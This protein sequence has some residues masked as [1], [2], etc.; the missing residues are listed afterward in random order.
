MGEQV[1][2]HLTSYSTE[3]IR[4]GVI[5]G[6]VGKAYQLQL[7][8]NG[9]DILV[10]TPGRLLELLKTNT[11]EF[12]DD[13][14]TNTSGFLLD[15]S[16]IEFF[17]VDECDKMLNMGFVADLREIFTYLPRPVK[18]KETTKDPLFDDDLDLEKLAVLMTRQTGNFK[19]TQVMMFSATL[20]RGVEDLM[21]RFAPVHKLVNL[22]AD[23][24]VAGNIKHVQYHVSSLLKKYNLL[25]YLIKR[26]GWKGKQVLVFARTRQKADRLAERLQE[27]GIHAFSIHKG[28]S[29][30]VR[31]KAIKDFK[32]Y[33]ENLE[34]EKLLQEGDKKPNL[35]QV[36]ISTDVLARGIDVENLPFVVNYDVPSQPE[37]YV[38][39]VG[40]TGRAGN[41]GMAVSIVNMSPQVI[42][43]GHQPVELNELH[44]MNTIERFIKQRVEHRKIP[45]T[46]TDPDL[47]KLTDTKAG[48]LP[49]LIDKM[50]I[51]SRQRGLEIL[52]KKQETVKKQMQHVKNSVQDNSSQNLKTLK[53]MSESYYR[54]KQRAGQMGT[55]MNDLVQRA[56]TRKDKKVLDNL[57]TLRNFKEGR[58]E[59]VVSGFE[60]HRALSRGAIKEQTKW[61]SGRKTKH[62]KII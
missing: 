2:Q 11:G 6:G 10:A 46:W 29:V 51:E 48:N 27:H 5:I 18:K 60:K 38:H 53:N 16:Q 40:R 35:I 8:K 58:Y 4:T 34:K 44:F 17:V 25:K 36:L 7:L 22:N 59:D 30:A 12:D 50:M 32:K 21:L 45:G 9:L 49:S 28:K 52:Q 15:L 41:A 39:R 14:K 57:P 43:I 37:D 20:T 26:K 62:Y 3:A 56:T 1:A 55:N 31:A 47:G 54:L 42:T 61:K 23:M 24:Q 13:E 19:N 33:P